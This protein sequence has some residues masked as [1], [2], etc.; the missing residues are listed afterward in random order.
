ME[1][2]NIKKINELE[3]ENLRLKQMFAGLILENRTLKD[4][5]GKSLKT[6]DKV[7]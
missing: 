1:A 3:D 7:R 6:S 5:I 4:V 2:A